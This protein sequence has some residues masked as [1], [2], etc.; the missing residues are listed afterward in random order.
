LSKC[1]LL[2]LSGIP[3]EAKN[4][5][6]RADMTFDPLVTQCAVELYALR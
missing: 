6:F 1:P 3:T 4:V 2:A 5:R